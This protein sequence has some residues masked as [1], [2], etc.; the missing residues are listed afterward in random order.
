MNTTKAPDRKPPGW[1]VSRR[2]RPVLHWIT[3][4]NIWLFRKTG[5]KIG[6]RLVG[7]PVVLLTT[8]G[9]KSG[10][11]RTVA[12]L[13]LDDGDRE[14]IVASQGGHPKHPAWYLNLSADPAVQVELGKGL[15]RRV[16]R[17]VADEER[18]ALWPRLV[19]MYPSYADYQSWCPRVIP[20]VALEPDGGAA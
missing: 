4:V 14:I 18:S 13:Y 8:R 11:E 6:G 10:L 7:A 15:Q 1:L 19:E 16:A 17:T 5:G 20:V 3:R 9:R 2:F 12:L